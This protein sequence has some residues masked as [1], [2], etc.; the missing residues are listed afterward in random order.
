MD[1]QLSSFTFNREY[2]CLCEINLENE[3][4]KRYRNYPKAVVICFIRHGFHNINDI[5]MLFEDKKNY[6]VRNLGPKR[7]LLAQRLVEK[8]EAE[9]LLK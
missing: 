2:R 3:L 7:R 9:A 1:N 4:K 8:Y 5:K 6:D